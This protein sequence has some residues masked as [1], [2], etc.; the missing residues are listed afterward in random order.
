MSNNKAMSASLN[1]QSRLFKIIQKKLDSKNF[2]KTIASVLHLSDSAV[3]KRLNG[4]RVVSLEEVLLLIDHFD[5]HLED[6][7]I[8]DNKTLRKKR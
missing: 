3:Y 6:V 1:C 8:E 7:F 2:V 4:S 5:V